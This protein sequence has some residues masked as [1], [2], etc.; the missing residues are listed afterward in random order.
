MK[1]TP[2]MA[3]VLRSF[4]ET[5]PGA[6]FVEIGLGRAG[7]SLYE[8]GAT[9]GW[10]GVVVDPLPRAL[11]RFEQHGPPPRIAF[12]QAAI[13]SQNGEARAFFAVSGPSAG[14][15]ETAIPRVNGALRREV[16][17]FPGHYFP[18]IEDRVEQHRT[19]WLTFDALCERHHLDR[20]DVVGIT[21]A[22]DE[23]EILE[24]IDLRRYRAAVIT[25]DHSILGSGVRERALMR[26]RG[27]GYQVIELA[28]ETWCLNKAFLP[29]DCRAQVTRAWRRVSWSGRSRRGIARLRSLGAT[30]PR[31][32][33]RLFQR[34]SDRAEDS[35]DT[36]QMAPV[37]DDAARYLNW[38]NPRL[39]EL[40]RIYRSVELPRAAGHVVWAPEKVRE[41]VELERFRADNL[42]VWQY[43]ESSRI[44]TLIFFA[45]MTHVLSRGGK[46]L[47]EK[48]GE[49]GAF[50]AWT[51][52]VRGHPRASRDLLDSVNEIL[53]L[54][55]ELDILA[56]GCRRIL[57][58]GAGYGR[59]AH[60]LTE[61]V[62]EI[63]DY[64]CVD[65]IPE[66]TFLCEYY[67]DYRGASPPARA[68]TLAELPAIE[69]GSF[70]LAINV[71]SFSECTLA[72]VEWWVS[73]L[74]RLRV[75]KLFIVPNEADGILSKET[76]GSYRSVL[77]VLADAGYLQIAKERAINDPAVRDVTGLNDNFYL[78]S[79]E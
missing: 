78:F 41:D 14:Q 72:F 70:D 24:Q 23:A 26:L 48:L 32:L 79:L 58:I 25:F 74:K 15:S 46:E 65:A 55:R 62:S 59:L 56:G 50:G 42:Y 16:L 47:L 75:P 2:Q 36:G 28:E 7:G 69:K 61:V 21:T 9:H 8:F 60:R 52:E 13:A 17:F 37:D 53:F 4:A 22:G 54:D 45:Y 33:D 43:S 11:A 6:R 49:D 73:Q 35:Q 66:S 3:E 57:D 44:R 29:A 5:E 63:E 10:S 18:G 19:R 30:A 34:E 67:L 76:D 64:C 77:P 71:H 51:L 68:I 31:G 20:C 40:R 12:E 39:L 38:D 1:G 27:A